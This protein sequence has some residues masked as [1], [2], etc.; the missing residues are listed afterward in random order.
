VLCGA[1]AGFPGCSWSCQFPCRYG[2]DSNVYIHTYIH[3]CTHAVYMHAPVSFC[4][5]DRLLPQTTGAL[6][7]TAGSPRAPGHC[8]GRTLSCLLLQ[9][10]FYSAIRLEDTAPRKVQ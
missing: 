8:Q 4:P 9:C 6:F 7:M 10:G 5:R 1:H 2:R 3:A